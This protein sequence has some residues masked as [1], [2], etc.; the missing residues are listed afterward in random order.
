M[1][2]VNDLKRQI[3]VAER[4]GRRAFRQDWHGFLRRQL[5]QQIRLHS[6][7]PPVGAPPQVVDGAVVM[8]TGPRH[9]RQPRADPG[10]HPARTLNRQPGLS[11]AST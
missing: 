8:P 10:R 1:E 11:T 4:R 7:A 5:G 3:E 2:H 6:E 9:R